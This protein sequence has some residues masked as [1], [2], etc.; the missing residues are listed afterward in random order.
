M[1]RFEVKVRRPSIVIAKR[2]VAMAPVPRP[3][4]YITEF[5]L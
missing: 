5:E 1:G 4:V 3:K 2:A